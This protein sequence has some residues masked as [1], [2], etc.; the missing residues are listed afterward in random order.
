[1]TARP[2]PWLS[3]ILILAVVSLLKNDDVEVRLMRPPPPGEKPGF[4]LFPMTRHKD[5]CGF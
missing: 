3:L 5:D 1:M 4:G 2:F